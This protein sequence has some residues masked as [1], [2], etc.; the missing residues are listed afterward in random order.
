MFETVLIY[1]LFGFRYA[2]ISSP[3]S[4]CNASANA[5]ADTAATAALVVTLMVSSATL[6]YCV[7]FGTAILNIFNTQAEYSVLSSSL[8]SGHE[9]SDAS[10]S[11]SQSRL[12]GIERPRAGGDYGT[13]DTGNDR[14]G[15]AGSGGTKHE[16]V[17]FHALMMLVACYGAMLLTN[18]GA[19]DGST[20]AASAATASQSLWLKIVSQWIFYS[21]FVELFN[22]HT[23]K[24]PRAKAGNPTSIMPRIHLISYCTLFRF[25]SDQTDLEN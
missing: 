4:A 13:R 3:D 8:L 21:L 2:V 12:T 16:I 25:M 19:A 20:L 23:M 1:Y 22:W 6:L 17:F 9:E 11:Q 14:G 5:T 10:A 24:I 18:W 15:D 7:F